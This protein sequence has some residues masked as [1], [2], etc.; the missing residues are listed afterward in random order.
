[1]SKPVTTCG[2]TSL[3]APLIRN[4]FITGRHF[5]FGPPLFFPFSAEALYI[6]DWHFDP[7]ATL[8]D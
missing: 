1:M 3:H 7:P 5:F 4:F 2:G 6:M 8:E